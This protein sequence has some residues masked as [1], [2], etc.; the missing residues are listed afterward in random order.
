M[1]D[2]D[3]Y[4]APTMP[5]P[6]KDDFTWVYVYKNGETLFS[7]SATSYHE[8]T[9]ELRSLVSE[10]VFNEKAYRDAVHEYHAAEAKLFEEFKADLLE[11][12]GVT[13]NPKADLAFWLANDY[14]HSFG[15]S[16]IASYFEDLVELIK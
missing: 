2:F 9:A 4:K 8:Q 13:N 12:N 1:K 5:W 10:K 7:G 3:Y 15:F 6:L 14:G 11:D 16:E